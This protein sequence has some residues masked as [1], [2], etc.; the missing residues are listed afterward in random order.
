MVE[1]LFVSVVPTVRCR[2]V[3]GHIVVC[4]GVIGNGR[5]KKAQQPTLKQQIHLV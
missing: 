3:R 2:P 1:W 4:Y 5:A